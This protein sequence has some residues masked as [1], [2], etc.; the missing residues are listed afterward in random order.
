MEYNYSNNSTDTIIVTSPT[1]YVCKENNKI[2]VDK[3]KYESWDSGDLL[4]QEA[5]P[6]LGPDEREIFMTGIHPKCWDKMFGN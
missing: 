3:S 6:F 2:I 5:F 1:C 4:I